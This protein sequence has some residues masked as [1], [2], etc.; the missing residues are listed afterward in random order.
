MGKLF[1]IVKNNPVV[2]GLGFLVLAG[3]GAFL[4]FGVFGIQAAF[5]DDVASEEEIA[6]NQDL[7]DSFQNASGD[8]EDN[9]EEDAD[10][11]S[12]A[13]DVPD[14]DP[15]DTVP[16]E[17]E[18]TDTTVAGE[19]VTGEDDAD[20]TA[21]ETTESP[22]EDEPTTTQAPTTAAPANVS[23]SGTFVDAPSYESEGS[24]QILSNGSETRVFISDDFQT[25]NGPDLKVYLRAANGDFINLGDLQNN[26]GSSNYL[27]P[28]GTDL[29]VFST[30]EIWC[31]RF[32]GR[33]GSAAVA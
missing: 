18:N 29:S 25:D 28:A 14:N 19:D 8:A 21:T 4:A 9:S 12:E 16:G 10:S 33:F 17:Q 5:I 20:E 2:S 27:V 6:A 30:V 26:I 7:L 11:D 31:Q 32:G 15:G 24:V 3:V 1:D 13:S 23:L 22:V